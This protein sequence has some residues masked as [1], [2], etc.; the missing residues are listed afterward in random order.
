MLCVGG[1]KHIL[2]NHTVTLRERKF[3]LSET[4][5]LTEYH[6]HH[7]EHCRIDYFLF[8]TI[9]Y[10]VAKNRYCRSIYKLFF[11][12]LMYVGL[13]CASL[14]Q[15]YSFEALKFWIDSSYIQC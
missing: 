1:L 8:K 6:A 2:A 13:V 5:I 15:T 11:T 9:T 14:L 10:S 3:F 7:S 12:E 4:F